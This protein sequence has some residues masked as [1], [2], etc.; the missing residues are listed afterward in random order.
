MGVRC[1]SI[2]VRCM[3]PA[4]RSL[5]YPAGPFVESG[6]DLSRVFFAEKSQPFRYP[7]GPR[8]FGERIFRQSGFETLKRNGMSV[9]ITRLVGKRYGFDRGFSE[10]RQS[11]V[12]A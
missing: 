12:F 1:A 6:R 4:A 10:A 3:V 9:V 2:G 5:R 7:F 8:S 11:G